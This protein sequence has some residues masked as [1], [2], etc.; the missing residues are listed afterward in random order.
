MAI[1]LLFLKT[2]LGKGGIQRQWI[3]LSAHSGSFGVLTFNAVVFT[4][5][6]PYVLYVRHNEM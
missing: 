4:H 2:D 6:P 3:C 5:S 1:L